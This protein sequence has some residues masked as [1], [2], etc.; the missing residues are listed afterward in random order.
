MS[1]YLLIFLY[2]IAHGPNPTGTMQLQNY[3]PFYSVHEVGTVNINPSPNSVV[4]V[5]QLKEVR[6]VRSS[7]PETWLWRNATVG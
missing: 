1:L 2:L 5:L 4:P 6:H 7:F 3:R